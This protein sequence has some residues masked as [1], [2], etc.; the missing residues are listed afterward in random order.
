M[1]NMREAAMRRR[2]DRAWTPALAID[3]FSGVAVN[4]DWTGSIPA[5]PNWRAVLR[6]DEPGTIA[7][8]EDGEM[9]LTWPN[10]ASLVHL[11]TFLPLPA[12]VQG[13][14]LQVRIVLTSNT[15]ADLL[16]V[17]VAIVL[18]HRRGDDFFNSLSLRD[19]RI[20]RT[21]E[22]GTQAIAEG[23]LDELPAS[24]DPFKLLFRL[25]PAASELAVRSVEVFTRVVAADHAPPPAEEVA[26]PPEPARL[27]PAAM[28]LSL[29]TPVAVHHGLPR[30]IQPLPAPTAAMADTAV[31]D[32]L[33]ALRGDVA[34]LAA[35]LA[36]RM[37]VEAADTTVE[38]LTAEVAAL[39]RQYEETR[40]ALL[41]QVAG[42]SAENDRLR[43]EV[44]RLSAAPAIE[45]RKR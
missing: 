17:L 2:N 39:V 38:R 43:R 45:E 7:C 28:P 19:M 18:Q 10:S 24:Q 9:R 4:R 37:P 44:D 15:V 3:D 12:P 41:E 26:A 21:A 23:V 16:R 6:A 35:V 42:L 1:T 8:T 40:Q 5:D 29:P 13:S 11:F 31:R 14:A 36:I 27:A 30:L 34:R 22:G 25:N 33:A 32:E 20:V